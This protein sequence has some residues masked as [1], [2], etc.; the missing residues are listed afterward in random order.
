VELQIALRIHANDRVR[1]ILTSIKELDTPDVKLP[2]CC[3]AAA[4]N[5]AAGLEL[6]QKA[7]ANVNAADAQGNTPLHHAVNHVAVDVIKKLGEFK[8]VDPNS[9]N[10]D[11]HTPLVIAVSGDSSMTGSQM[12]RTVLKMRR[13][14]VGLLI[15]NAA[16]INRKVPAA[17][18]LIGAFKKVDPN[19][20]AK[21]R[22]SRTPLIIAVESGNELCVK[23]LLAHPKIDANMLDER[24]RTA[25]TAAIWLKTDCTR[26]LVSQKIDM[27]K[28]SPGKRWSAIHIAILSNN[29]E[30]LGQLL[31]H[32]GV[33]IT[34]QDSMGWTALHLA[35][36][37]K[38]VKALTMLLACPRIRDDSF[39]IC[40][41]M[42][43]ASSMRLRGDKVGSG[44][45]LDAT[46]EIY[47]ELPG[48]LFA[49]QQWDTLHEVKACNRPINRR[50][51]PFIA[52][53][54]RCLDAQIA[55]LVDCCV[56]CR[57]FHVTI[58]TNQWTHADV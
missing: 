36:R 58:C 32:P 8:D 23:M 18:A 24:G 20:T 5:N 17:T 40:Q 7:G 33:D 53:K 42:R 38:N 21:D 31:E 37:D 13:K 50:M 35:M 46:P 56:N 48:M 1:L 10:A 11:G 4:A 9:H 57:G 16:V 52:P 55:S 45:W 14:S 12:K 15:N 27:N 41:N 26:L 34:Q 6:L 39:M 29:L 51:Q 44:F 25:L 49:S 19:T 54:K 30:A 28:A 22:H 43:T 3:Q 2:Y 47:Q